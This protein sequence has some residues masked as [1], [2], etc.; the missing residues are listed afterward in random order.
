MTT[1]E[2]MKENIELFSKND[3]TSREENEL[4]DRVV[5]TMVDF[6]PSTVCKYC[7][8]ACPQGL[9]IPKLLSMSNE[10]RF[11][12]SFLLHFNLGSMPEGKLPGACSSCGECN[13]LCPQGINIPS[14]MEGF[15]E[16]FAKKPAW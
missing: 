4:L 12:N 7:L 1:M 2:Q 6:V 15:A 5:K 16:G 13:K 10:Q 3:P 14:I 11:D 8:E 9:D